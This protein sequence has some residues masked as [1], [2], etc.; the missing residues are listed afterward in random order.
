MADVVGLRVR[1]PVTQE[2]TLDI[3][4]R[5]TRTIG[6]VD[7]GT[8]DGFID[9]PAFAEGTPWFVLSGPAFTTPFQFGS[10][11]VASIT[12]TRLSWTFKAT[13]N[14]PNVADTITY[15]VY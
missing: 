15:G 9:V 12:G 4:D 5:I 14:R 11:V 1:D 7:T 6:Q 10:Y 13:P 3:T 2:I 8:N